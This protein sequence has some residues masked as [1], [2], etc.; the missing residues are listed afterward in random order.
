MSNG[1][2]K[3]SGKSCFP[4]LVTQ[5][6]VDVKQS[7]RISFRIRASLDKKMRISCPLL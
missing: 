7:G 2:G 1:K 4:I 6:V 5:R 3:L